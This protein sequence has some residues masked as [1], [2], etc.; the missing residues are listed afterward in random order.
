MCLEVANISIK[1]CGAAHEESSSHVAGI[2]YWTS[3][4]ATVNAIPWR[5]V[6][7]TIVEI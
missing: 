1:K 3:C 5:K 7:G 6:K 2:K 4:Q